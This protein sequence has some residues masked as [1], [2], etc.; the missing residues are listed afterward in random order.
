LKSDSGGEIGS[1]GGKNGYW[2]IGANAGDGFPFLFF[3]WSIKSS[4]A[5]P[6][7]IGDGKADVTFAVLSDAIAGSPSNNAVPSFLIIS[8]AKFFCSANVK[9]YDLAIKDYSFSYYKFILA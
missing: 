5:V 7:D 8:F 6:G 9:F 2:G 4:F 1:K 3:L